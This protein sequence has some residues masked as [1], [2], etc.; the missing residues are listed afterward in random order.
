MAA[1]LGLATVT[2]AMGACPAG[3]FDNDSLSNAQEDT[4]GNG[5]CTDDDA[6]GGHPEL[7]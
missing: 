3:D 7:R 4:N 1:G 6:D 2:G 5:D